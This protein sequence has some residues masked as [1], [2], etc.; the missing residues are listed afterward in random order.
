ML[1][2]GPGGRPPAPADHRRPRTPG[3]ESGPRLRAM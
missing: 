3:P 2:A 1:L